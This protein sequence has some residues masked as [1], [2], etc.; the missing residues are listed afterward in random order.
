[1]I[2]FNDYLWSL[3]QFPQKVT[4]SAPLEGIKLLALIMM[5][6]AKQ[7]TWN[8]EEIRLRIPRRFEVETQ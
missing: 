2:D 6:G 7:S 3:H 5:K 1:M 4:V 8:Q